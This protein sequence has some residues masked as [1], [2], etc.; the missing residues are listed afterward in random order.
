MRNIRIIFLQNMVHGTTHLVYVRLSM[1]RGSGSSRRMPNTKQQCRISHCMHRVAYRL[2]KIV[3]IL[4]GTRPTIYLGVIRIM[5]KYMLGVSFM[6]WGRC[7]LLCSIR[8]AGGGT[9]GAPIC[10]GYLYPPWLIKRL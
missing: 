1:Q 10:G 2:Y 6:S 3:H 9:I 8:I 7:K 5:I 4:Q